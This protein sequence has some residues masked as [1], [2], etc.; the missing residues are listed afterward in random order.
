MIQEDVMKS[1][2]LALLAAVFALPGTGAV[3]QTI[4]ARI[5]FESRSFPQAPLIEGLPHASASIAGQ[6]EL[7]VQWGEG[8]NRLHAEPFVR[9]DGTDAARTHFDLRE[10]YWQRIAYDWEL[11]IGWSRVFWGVT[12]SQHLVDVVNQTD[13]VEGP[14]GEDKLGQPMV[15]F[16]LFRDWG[17]IELF[18]LPW[19]RER[20]FPGPGGRLRYPLE[21][22]EDRSRR[23][24]RVDLAVRWSHAV[25]SLDIGLSHFNGTNREPDFTLVE[26]PDEQPVLLPDYAMMNQTGLD[27]QVTRGG[28][29]WK[30]EAR[31]R[32][33]RGEWSGAVVGGVEYTF[34]D[35]SGTGADLGLLA[36]Y[37][38]DSRK[39]VDLSGLMQAPGAR[40]APEGETA[41]GEESGYRA[42]APE[43]GA[44]AGGALAGGAL[45]GGG[46]AGGAVARDGIGAQPGSLPAKP[47]SLTPYNDDVFAGVRLALNDVNST[48]VLAGVLVDRSNGSMSLSA[49]AERRVG[50]RW[51]LG[52]EGYAFLNTAPSDPFHVMRRD[53]HL[54]VVVSRYL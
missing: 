22:D 24:E 7:F 45:A 44:I 3:G 33:A 12:E 11:K 2:V 40:S 29:L 16:S 14:T 34:G 53:G 30:V 5:D 31:S 27:L 26:G 54:R 36:E 13:L 41:A 43:G 20:T 42:E 50:E 47:L 18:A 4:N 39:M 52:V 35:I 21:I 6:P 23:S 9:L 28:F 49:E 38:Y 51:T 8:A 19:F 17:M 15:H 48:S 10:L 37:H 1:L 46:V 25:G 32:H